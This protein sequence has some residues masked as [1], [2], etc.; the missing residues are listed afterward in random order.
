MW[1]SLFNEAPLG[2]EPMS[3]SPRQAVLHLGVGFWNHF[4]SVSLKHLDGDKFKM[5]RQGS[6]KQKAIR[7]SIC[8]IQNVWRRH[9]LWHFKTKWQEGSCSLHSKKVHVSLLA[10]YK[11]CTVMLD[12]TLVHLWNDMTRVNVIYGVVTRQQKESA[13]KVFLIVCKWQLLD[14]YFIFVVSPACKI[15]TTVQF[16]IAGLINNSLVTGRYWVDPWVRDIDTALC[17]WTLCI[18][19]FIQ[20]KMQR[21]LHRTSL[22]GIC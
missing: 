8:W 4:L 11:S 22:V 10:Y 12:A 6:R 18:N 17:V 16:I 14:G 1:G 21:S 3:I 13:T 15:V 5:R 7:Q 19:W 9:C 20:K 2:V